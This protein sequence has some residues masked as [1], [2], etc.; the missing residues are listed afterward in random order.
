MERLLFLFI[1]FFIDQQ[2]HHHHDEMASN[3][4][5]KDMAAMATKCA[6]EGGKGWWG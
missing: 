5:H 4:D 2:Q 3:R 1:N 6:N